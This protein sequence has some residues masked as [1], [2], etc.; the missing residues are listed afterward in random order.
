MSGPLRPL[1]LLFF[2]SIEVETKFAFANSISE[3][4]RSQDPKRTTAILRKRSGYS[5]VGKG[6]I[7]RDGLVSLGGIRSIA[8]RAPLPACRDGIRVRAGLREFQVGPAS[9]I[10]TIAKTHSSNRALLQ[11]L[12]LR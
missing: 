10:P 4:S 5:E 2:K 11:Q 6:T 12:E 1:A 7:E 9:C 8:N 3:F